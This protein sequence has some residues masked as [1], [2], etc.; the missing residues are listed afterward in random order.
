MDDLARVVLDHVDGVEEVPVEP[1][2]HHETVFHG[3]VGAAADPGQVE[4]QF[5]LEQLLVEGL[6]RDAVVAE[7]EVAW[8][9]TEHMVREGT[10]DQQGVV[11]QRCQAGAEAGVVEPGAD[12]EE[13]N[14]GLGGSAPI[15]LAIDEV[16]VRVLHSQREL[17]DDRGK[18]PPADTGGDLGSVAIPDGFQIHLEVHKGSILLVDGRPQGVEELDGVLSRKIRSPRLVDQLSPF[19]GSGG[20]E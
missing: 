10:V 4:R 7:H 9:E 2:A 17:V 16:G 13:G 5:C 3:G 18:T 1:G 6:P 14:A 15:D 19:L 12:H 11:G 8:F 20:G